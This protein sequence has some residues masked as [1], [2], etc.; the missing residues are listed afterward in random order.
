MKRN[1]LLRSILLTCVCLLFTSFG[2][3]V[4]AQKPATEGTLHAVDAQGQPT[5]VCPL[6]HTDVKADI[7][8]F[9]A[10]VTVT[11]QF[12]NPFADK[13]EAVYTFPLP[14]AA[15]VDDMTIVIGE[16]VVKGKI[17]RR[18][19]A[20]A[21]YEAA[22]ARGQTAA[23]LNQQ[24]PNIFTQAV[25]NILPGQQINVTISYVETLK[26]DDGS[27]EWHFP[28][29]VGERYIPGTKNSDQVANPGQTDAPQHVA[30]DSPCVPDAALITPPVMP[31]GMRAGHD[32]SIQV[33]IE[34][35]V[36]LI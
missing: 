16:R 21:T 2:H 8:G 11:Q 34:A 23:L 15:A 9:I 12:Q 14:Q 27:Y 10:R 26:Y 32:I 25:A 13:I 4:L 24:R 20:Q 30:T 36:P 33:N 35:G 5:G 18:E 29:V 1:H 28:M 3:E 17:M 6:K 7:S 19:E 22:R 31:K